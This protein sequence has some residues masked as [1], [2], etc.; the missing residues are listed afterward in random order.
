MRHWKLAKRTL[1]ALALLVVPAVV[2]ASAAMAGSAGVVGSPPSVWS[3]A[4]T[5]LA[6]DAAST[7]G[8]PS[9]AGRTSPAPPVLSS[10]D[11]ATKAAQSAGF[12]LHVSGSGFESTGTVYWDSYALAADIAT[13]GS[14]TDLYALV[15]AN[16]VS[17][18]G[19]ADIT[20]RNNGSGLSSGSLPFSVVG[21]TVSGITPASAANTAAAQVI[22]VSG[23]GL[24]YASSPGI[25]LQGVVGTPTAA[26]TIVA[27]GVSLVPGSETHI[28]GTVDLAT[29]G[30]GGTPAPAGPYRVVLS[31]T[32]DGPKSLT[33]SGTFT[34][35]GP[36]PHIDSLTPSSAA[37]YGPAFT[38]HVAG[39]SFEAGTAQVYWGS[40]LLVATTPAG[41]STDLYVTVP[42]V[43]LATRT[44][45]SI[46]V[47]NPGSAATS[48]AVSFSVT[49]PSV[50]AIT[51]NSGVNTNAALGIEL[52]GI[53]L[54]LAVS[55]GIV[56]RGVTGTATA[57]T[58]I[59]ATGVSLV[60]GSTTRMSGTVN[61]AT[62][63]AGGTNAPAGSYDVVLNYIQDG[64]KTL[65]LAGAFTVTGSAPVIMSITPSSA[66][67]QNGALT[68]R[69]DGSNFNTGPLASEVRWD[70][71]A[72]PLTTPA[73]TGSTIY[74]TLSAERLKVPGTFAVTV[75]DPNLGG[76]VSSN[77]VTF[78]VV[79]PTIKTMSPA[80]AANTV[81]SLAFELSG[82]GLSYAVNP[83]ITLT[84][85]AG[86]ATAGVTITAGSVARVGETKLTGTLNLAAVG[87]SSAPAPAG[88]Y[89]VT[90]TYEQSGIK[91]L[92]LAEGF[93][94][95]GASFTSIEPTS[96]TNGAAAVTLTLKGTGLKGLSSPIVTLKGPGPI[97]TAV[98]TGAGVTVANDGLTMTAVFNLTSPTVV[99]AGLY[100]VVITYGAGAGKLTLAQALSVNN[101][102]P[103]VTVLSPPTVYAGSIKPTT[104]T[105]NGAGFVPVPLLLGAT[106]SVIHVGVRTTTDTT[107]VGATQLSVPLL[108]SDIAFPGAVPI[109]VV[110]PAPGGGTSAPVNLTVASETTLPTC[111]LS[112]YD[113][114]WHNTPV[115]LTVT[116]IDTESGVQF[117]QSR[118]DSASWSTLAGTTIVVPAPADHSGDGAKLVQARATDWCNKVQSQPT[119]ATVYID[120]RGP[121]TTASCP[122]SVTKGKKLTLTYKAS[123]ALSPTCAVTLKIKNS[124]GDW[125]KS[126]SLGQKRSNAKGTYTFT[127]NLPKGTYRYYVY[128]KDLAGNKQT[129]VGSTSFKVK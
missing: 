110:N 19:S 30:A 101:A 87:T 39:S 25:T 90:L 32:Q 86:T 56:L 129:A 116:A 18:P 40:T 9:G 121:K 97:G 41:T 8:V 44:T 29:G 31:Y 85:I 88:K 61:L 24:N 35:T 72:L 76:G 3:P 22:T 93:V 7:A 20:V 55:P 16:L 99:Q 58:T 4:W 71:V 43:L 67:A 21:P 123:D 45:A 107:V 106:G 117:V 73:A 126:W 27:T 78:S 105:V 83:K 77:A 122:S 42:A 108:A 47:R 118:I 15:P 79:G 113:L 6:A 70:G 91:T 68:L 26:T 51:P 34:V 128:A 111:T 119:D 28:T 2:P 127:C 5:L 13:P 36:S 94:V 54:D 98:V 64:S 114:A 59:T 81:T 1:V 53:D 82:T 115:T 112:G 12:T 66:P 33:L 120:T 57:G 92:T 48:N 125:V 95:T 69:V 75:Y 49:G 46:T 84:G 52:T 89:D 62:A 100:D 96:T 80:T 63:G 65:T 10:L 124:R 103:V 74:A 102:L 17:V 11:P 14:T 50:S 109:T 23:T 38:L 37:A 60:P 104:L